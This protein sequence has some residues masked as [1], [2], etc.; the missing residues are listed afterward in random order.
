MAPQRYRI[1]AV[2]GMIVVGIDQ[3]SKKVIVDRFALYEALEL[4]E[5]FFHITYVRNK[6]AAFG[7]LAGSP[8][9]LPFFIAVTLVACG[10][11]IGYLRRLPDD[12]KMAATALA[13]IFGG[14]IG[15]LIDRVR[16]GEVIDFI[17]VHWYQYHWPAFN[18][19]DSAICVG[20]GLLLL[21]TW[22]HDR[23]AARPTG[24]DAP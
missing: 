7:M 18:I 9:R 22:R 4:V 13:L 3:W 19:A 24:K 11:I 20:V 12:R 10:I 23:T 2:V 15:N 21:D 6:G 1:L 14:A 8:L 17:D 5:N 16:L